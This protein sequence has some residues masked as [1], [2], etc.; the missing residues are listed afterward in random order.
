MISANR[1]EALYRELEAG[2]PV[3]VAGSGA[4]T[5][6]IKGPRLTGDHPETAPFDIGGRRKH[7]IEELKEAVTS[8]LLHLVT[9]LFI[10]PAE[11]RL[12]RHAVRD[13]VEGLYEAERLCDSRGSGGPCR[14]AAHLARS[15]WGKEQWEPASNVGASCPLLAGFGLVEQAGFFE[16]QPH[17]IAS[18]TRIFLDIERYHRSDPDE[19]ESRLDRMKTLRMGIGGHTL[20]NLQDLHIW[21]ET[22]LLGEMNK[23]GWN[24]GAFTLRLSRELEGRVSPDLHPGIPLQGFLYVLLRSHQF[25]LSETIEPEERAR[26]EKV[27]ATREFD[28]LLDLMRV[29]VQRT[30]HRRDLPEVVFLLDQ[31]QKEGFNIKHEKFRD[32]YASDSVAVGDTERLEKCRLPLFLNLEGLSGDYHQDLLVGREDLLKL[33]RRIITEAVEELKAF[34]ASCVQPLPQAH[35]VHRLI[36]LA[37]GWFLA[38]EPWPLPEGAESGEE[39][40]RQLL[41]DDVIRTLVRP[42]KGYELGSKHELK[43]IMEDEEK[44]QRGALERIQATGVVQGHHDYAVFARCL[45]FRMLQRDLGLTLKDPSM[46]ERV[47]GKDA[48]EAE[49]LEWVV[50]RADALSIDAVGGWAHTLDAVREHL[51]QRTPAAPPEARVEEPA[52]ESFAG[53]LDAVAP[54]YYRLIVAL[55]RHQSNLPRL[56]VTGSWREEIDLLVKLLAPTHA[57]IEMMASRD[58]R[59]AFLRAKSA[60]YRAQTRPFVVNSREWQAAMAW[61]VHCRI[62]RDPSAFLENADLD[63]FLEEVSRAAEKVDRTPGP[64]FLETPRGAILSVLG[65]D[66]GTSDLDREA[67]SELVRALPQLDC[68]ACGEASCRNFAQALLRGRAEPSAC[69]QLSPQG[70]TRL[71]ERFGALM[72]K[73]PDGNASASLLEALRDRAQWRRMGERDSFCVVLSPVCRKARSLFLERLRDVWEG[74]SPKPEI[75]RC[76]S[77]EAFYG[78]LCRYLGYESAERLTDEER[79]L[80]VDRGDAREEAAWHLF[81][82]KQDW[83]ALAVKNRQGKPLLRA[84]DPAWVAAQGYADLLFLHQLSPRDRSLVLWDR[85]ERHQ[86]GFRQWWNEDL[87]I[88]NHPDFSIHDWEDFT[89]IIKNAYWHQEY[90]LAPGD[91]L[92]SLRGSHFSEE[93]S[94]SAGAPGELLRRHLDH[95]V[96]LE[97]KDFLRRVER[98]GEV[99]RGRG[100][101]DMTELRFVLEALVDEH[102]LARSSCPGPRLPFGDQAVVDVEGIWDRFQAESIAFSPRFSC[103]WEDLSASEQEALAGEMGSEGGIAGPQ[104]DGGVFLEG[105]SG[106]LAKRAAL[107]RA[108]VLVMTGHRA[109]EEAEARWLKEGIGGTLPERPPLGSF[110]VLVRR[111]MRNGCG[112]HTVQEELDSVLKDLEARRELLAALEDDVLHKAIRKGAPRVLLEARRPPAGRSESSEDDFLGKIPGLANSLEGL[113]QAQPPMDR[114]R[115]LHYLFLLAKMEGNLDTLTALLREIRETSDVMEAAWLRFTEE[116]ILEGPPP[117][118]SPGTGLGIRLLFSHLQ[119][120]GPVNA[121]LAKGVGRREKRNVASAANELLDFLRYHLL[122][123]SND[124]DAP[125]ADKAVQDMLVAGYDLAGI[126]EE[127]LKAAANREWG[128]LEQLRKRKIWI[129][130]SVTARKLAAQHPELN[131]IERRFQKMRLE[132]LREGGHADHEQAEIVSRRG[133]ALG[134]IKGE[135]YRHLSDLLESERIATFQSRIRRI[136]DEIDEKRK[137]IVAGWS[138]GGINQRT[139]FYI[140]RQYQKSVPEPT[141]EDFLRFI[142]E[143]WLM[144]VFDFRSSVRPD[145]DERLKEL[146]ERI[147]AVLGV[148]LLDLEG[149]TAEAAEQDFQAWMEDQLGGSIGNVSESALFVVG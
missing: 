99:T 65:R 37:V 76:P 35:L 49:K 111:L 146:D 102:I 129:F 118:S 123:C 38:G 58:A 119:D 97:E 7:R 44:R 12:I 147:R 93:C 109:Q 4:P 8:Q 133:V 25:C 85:L 47:A 39:G 48:A 73:I 141:W 14:D 5:E 101:S 138:S 86:D 43:R 71:L 51:L 30:L 10:V 112:R 22:S 18:W 107:I 116:R 91:A 11:D 145:R 114:E 140:L 89:K 117:K 24:P 90:S 75:F 68:G 142:V 41:P 19:H 126:D 6:R 13:S 143:Q 53:F 20:S 32:P 87:L 104:G 69:V 95:V 16:R 36:R 62:G 74:L 63:G 29:V 3:R 103:R 122:L 28:S 110:R 67:L 45:L 26:L 88:L 96:D 40:I 98:R 9:T 148:S 64:L 125:G 27:N 1:R 94:S 21:L 33:H 70:L 82:Q 124:T 108:L 15:W 77:P 34:V 115:L 56:E 84:Q 127:A 128:R 131:E 92:K 54:V 42:R 132:I 106:S 72:E 46:G 136:V 105:W 81:R 144:P 149:E 31:L 130:T 2:F 17:E 80:L 135:M 61:A 137:E 78:E 55:G 113:F 121:C 23:S 100:V 57:R 134:Q 66:D 59:E 52:E 50:E 60:L 79:R 120:K 83:L 139:V